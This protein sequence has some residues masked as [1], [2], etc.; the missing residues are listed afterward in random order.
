MREITML[1]QELS[2]LCMS[3]NQETL[4]Y[5]LAALL[6]DMTIVANVGK[7]VLEP[8]AE[9]SATSNMRH[10]TLLFARGSEIAASTEVFLFL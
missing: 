7:G 9:C 2:I 1:C 10:L 6:L 3:A 5:A 8:S 4:R